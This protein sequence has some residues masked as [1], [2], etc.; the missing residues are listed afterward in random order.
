[1]QRPTVRSMRPSE[2]GRDVLRVASVDPPTDRDLLNWLDEAAD[3][4][5]VAERKAG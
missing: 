1:M 3:G 2:G 5:S 4:N